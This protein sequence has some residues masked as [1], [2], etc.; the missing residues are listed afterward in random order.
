MRLN[1]IKCNT[2]GQGNPGIWYS[3]GMQ[4]LKAA[5]EKDMVVLAD[6]KLSMIQHSQLRKPNVSCA[7]AQ[8]E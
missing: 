8:E 1:R 5:L 7:A 3:Q 6:E 4:R 2:Q